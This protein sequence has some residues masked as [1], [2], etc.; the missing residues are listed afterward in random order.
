MPPLIDR[1]R[2]PT[3][4][5]VSAAI[6]GALLLGPIAGAGLW[7]QGRPVV[8]AAPLVEA[9]GVHAGSLVKLAL[10]VALPDGVHVQ[11]DKPRDPL[12][13]A[14]RLT[15]EPPAG[16]TTSEIVYP[17]ST[18]FVQQGQAQPLAVFE[19]EFVVGIAVTLAGDV[20]PGPI[21]V[22]ARLRY[23]ACDASTCYAPARHDATF[24]LHVV[25][26]SRTVKPLA[27]D[28]FAR[29]RFSR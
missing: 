5:A 25:P 13:I 6:A 4:Y 17:P 10:R 21:D 7:A 24:T 27:P 8:Q 15:V 18:D 11:S 28:L 14:T 23:Q 9:D 16:V 12:L 22:P 29:L 19:Q 2:L 26:Q 20:P 1:R 3:G